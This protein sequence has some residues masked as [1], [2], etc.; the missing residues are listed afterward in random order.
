MSV[1]RNS[2]FST[3]L[4]KSKESLSKVFEPV[5]MGWGTAILSFTTFDHYASV[6]NFLWKSASKFLVLNFP[7]NLANNAI[8]HLKIDWNM[9]V[10]KP[11]E[12]KDLILRTNSQY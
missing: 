9:A 2:V 7:I 10:N 4:W 5:K 3:L 12:P 6:L 8:F 11:F 1:T